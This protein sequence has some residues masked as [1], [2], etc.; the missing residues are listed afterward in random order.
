MASRAEFASSAT[1]RACS[2]ARGR[3]TKR[4]GSAS[5]AGSAMR[6]TARSRPMSKAPKRVSS[7]SSTASEKAHPA[8]TWRMCKSTKRHSK[9]STG[10][11]CGTSWGPGLSS[12]DRNVRNVRRR[13]GLISHRDERDLEG[14]F[15][16][17][18]KPLLTAGAVALLGLPTSTTASQYHHGDH[19]YYHA[20]G[21]HGGYA[22]SPYHHGHLAYH[23][24][25]YVHVAYH[26]A[27]HH[28]YGHMIYHYH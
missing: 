23:D 1:S 15:E 11:R 7:S 3:E 28:L 17:F 24:S 12:Q 19:H 18:A 13:S 26:S 20:S 16:M 5:A 6:R 8:R 27:Y 14:A 21:F 25:P 10:S 4:S 22:F 2:S 9:A